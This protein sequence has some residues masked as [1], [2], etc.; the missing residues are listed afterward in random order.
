MTSLLLILVSLIIR[1]W[2]TITKIWFT[3]RVRPEEDKQKADAKVPSPSHWRLLV[4]DQRR[5][6]HAQR[7]LPETTHN[8]SRK[9]TNAPM[10]KNYTAQTEQRTTITA[11]RRDT[12]PKEK[13]RATAHHRRDNKK[14]RETWI[15]KDPERRSPHTRTRTTKQLGV[16]IDLRLKN[17]H[18]PNPIP[19]RRP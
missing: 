2:L 10:E 16:A 7:S 13:P 9:T 3:N 8:A 14:S 6:E 5:R 18:R 4:V 19:K 17:D 15:W 12:T 1:T 11:L